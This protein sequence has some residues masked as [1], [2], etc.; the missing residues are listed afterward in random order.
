MVG[1]ESTEHSFIG[2]VLKEI[3]EG[4]QDQQKQTIIDIY[5]NRKVKDQASPGFKSHINHTNFFFF[6][7]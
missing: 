5:A 7:F 4:N 1:L 6:F 2:M 3:L